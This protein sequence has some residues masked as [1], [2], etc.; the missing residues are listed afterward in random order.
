MSHSFLLICTNDSLLEI[1][2]TIISRRLYLLEKHLLTS[3]N[4][5]IEHKLHICSFQKYFA[6]LK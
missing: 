4:H 5:F 3:L 2:S 1:Q 6:W